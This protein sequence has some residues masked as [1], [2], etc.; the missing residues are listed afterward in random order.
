MCHSI[1]IA[2]REKNRQQ[3]RQI[4]PLHYLF[5]VSVPCPVQVLLTRTLI[6]VC[7]SNYVRDHQY[8]QALEGFML[9]TSTSTSKISTLVT[10]TPEVSPM[11]S[12]YRQCKGELQW[13]SWPQ[14]VSSATKPYSRRTSDDSDMLGLRKREVDTSTGGIGGFDIGT[15]VIDIVNI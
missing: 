1:A 14:A 4:I 12:R 5:T 6:C 15:A 3:S 13:N 8:C 2:Q 7:I 11:V 10:S 9:A